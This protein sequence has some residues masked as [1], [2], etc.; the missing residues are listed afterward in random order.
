MSQVK[1]ERLRR[2]LLRRNILDA[3]DWEHPIDEIEQEIL[4]RRKGLNAEAIADML[5]HRVALKLITYAD[6]AAYLNQH[7]EPFS[8]RV[9]KGKNIRA[10]HR[11]WYEFI[12]PRNAHTMLA[13]PK[14]I[15]P[16]L[17]RKV[18]FALDTRGVVPQDSCIT[19]APGEKTRGNFAHLTQQLAGVLQR[20]ATMADVLKYSLAYLNSS[21]AQT[22][23]T[24]GRR[25]TPKGSY[26][27][28]D[29]FLREIPLP[30]P[31]PD[32]TEILALVTLLVESCAAAEQAEQ[33]E[34]L[35][36]VVLKTLGQ[37]C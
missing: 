26:Q 9:F 10:F 7:Y 32:A 12:W 33:E 16:R 37:D 25:P 24:S 14:I 35:N 5:R 11:N 30:P 1:D 20:E 27:V 2:E 8:E 18:R 34:R 4:R 15:T 17:T 21:Y 29:A 28:S 31:G 36:A 22:R 6:T 13:R 3:L 23:L 19:L